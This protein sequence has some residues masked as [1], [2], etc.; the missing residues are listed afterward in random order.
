MVKARCVTRVVSIRH[1]V[2]NVF[3][4]KKFEKIVK[5]CKKF[6]KNLKKFK[7]NSKF[8]NVFAAKKN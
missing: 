8:L 4:R 6:G 2:L 7:K 1:V 5:N 3:S